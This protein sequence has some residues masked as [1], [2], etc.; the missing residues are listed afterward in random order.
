MKCYK[1]RYQPLLLVYADSDTSEPVDRDSGATR[2]PVN[3]QSG[4][5]GGAGRGGGTG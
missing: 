5:G 4:G 1:G 3:Q 2:S